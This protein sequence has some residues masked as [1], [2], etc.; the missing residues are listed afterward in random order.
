[1][2]DIDRLERLEIILVLK[3]FALNFPLLSFLY[4]RV[5]LICISDTGTGKPHILP[6]SCTVSLCLLPVLPETHNSLPYKAQLVAFSL[7]IYC[8]HFPPVFLHLI[9]ARDIYSNKFYFTS[10]LSK[11]VFSPLNR[12]NLFPQCN[13]KFLRL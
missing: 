9:E 5:K 2:G 13:L 8:G 11:K 10:E 4:Q 6:E 3:T 1:M 12:S 7:L